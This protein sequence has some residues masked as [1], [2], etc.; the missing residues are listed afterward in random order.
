M[1]WEEVEEW[2]ETIIKFGAGGEK[3]KQG[4]MSLNLWT[5]QHNFFLITLIACKTRKV[6]LHGGTENGNKSWALRQGALVEL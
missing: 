4:F 2:V 1:A 5:L 6:F 3:V